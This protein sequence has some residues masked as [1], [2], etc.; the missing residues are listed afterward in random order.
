MLNVRVIVVQSVR[1]SKAKVGYSKGFRCFGS[2]LIRV[3][4]DL[5]NKQSGRVEN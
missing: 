3:A 2:S 4:M 5:I 1:E